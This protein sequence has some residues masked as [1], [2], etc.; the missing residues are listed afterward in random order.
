[1]PFNDKSRLMQGAEPCMEPYLWNIDCIMYL[2]MGTCSDLAH[3]VLKLAKF[4][5]SVTAIHWFAV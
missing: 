2:M 1:M 3:S 5:A 4:V